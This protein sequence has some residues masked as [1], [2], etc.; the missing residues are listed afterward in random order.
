MEFHFVE[1]NKTHMSTPRKVN[2]N[3]DNESIVV[4]GTCRGES[5]GSYIARWSDGTTLC[6]KED[7]TS[8]STVVDVAKTMY[9]MKT[10]KLLEIHQ[11]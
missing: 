11:T 1:F 5:D 6:I 8:L 2:I 9:E 4:G 10:Y 3:V 7:F